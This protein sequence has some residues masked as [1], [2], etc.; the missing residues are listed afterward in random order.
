MKTWKIS[1]FAGIIAILFL[2]VGCNEGDTLKGTWESSNEVLESIKIEFSGNKFTQTVTSDYLNLEDYIVEGT[3]IISG[4]QIEF[5]Y[6]HGEKWE[7]FF[8][9]DDDVITINEDIFTR[10]N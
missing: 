5:S 2:T 1:V 10:I 9:F 8:A 4:N 3:Y 6:S 7:A